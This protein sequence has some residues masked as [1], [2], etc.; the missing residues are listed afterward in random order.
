MLY[1][2]GRFRTI[3]FAIPIISV[4]NLRVGG[5]GKTPLTAY[6]LQQLCLKNYRVA[7]LSRGYRR[8]SKG[9]I[10]ADE[11]AT[12]FSI[13]DEPF[14]LYRRFGQ[15]GISVAVSEDRVVAVSL[16]VMDIENLQV[17]VL[18]D[19]FQHRSIKPHLSLLLTE[20]EQPYWQDAVLP[21]G[22]L[23]EPV[24]SAERADILIVTKCPKTLN[25]TERQTIKTAI[26]PKP[27]QKVLFSFLE[28]EQPYHCF[29]PQKTLNLHKGKPVFL[30]CGIADTKII[31]RYVRET[32]GT[33]ETLFYPNHYF[34]TKN[35]I[36]NISS[37]FK[38]FAKKQTT[39]NQDDAILLT[40]EK[41]AARLWAYKDN[42]DWAG[43]P[44][45]CLPIK[46]DFNADD[47]QTLQTAVL[48]CVEHVL[49][50]VKI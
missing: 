24:E 22:Y 46:I 29:D 38:A 50:K 45:Y 2:S 26:N 11:T 40:T 4:G 7:M 17:V 49:A 14:Q 5:T 32:A 25:D 37:H 13:G 36:K 41:D 43:L 28:Y 1:D 39:A 18:D 16:L 35:D 10:L 20:Y 23:R 6:L 42:D 27:H 44:L 30:F 15:Q 3:T 31:E 47:A 33:V 34:Y 48:G 9:F 21:L 12:A 8:H 19:A